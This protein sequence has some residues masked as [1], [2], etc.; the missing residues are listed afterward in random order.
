[1]ADRGFHVFASF[2]LSAILHVLSFVF[3]SWW[4]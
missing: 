4:F 1:M 3:C 2:V